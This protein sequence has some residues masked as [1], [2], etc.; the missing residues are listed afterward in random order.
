[1]LA[2]V[3]KAFK[4]LLTCLQTAKMYGTVHPMFVKSLDKAYA[5]FQDV[6]AQRQE[7]VIGIVGDELAWE[8]EIFFDLG[9]LLR[10]AILY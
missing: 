6:L 7:M 4:E 9:K 8:K 2:E 1:M 10:P 3:E 5:A